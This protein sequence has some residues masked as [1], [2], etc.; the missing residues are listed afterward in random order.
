M[1]SQIPYF[2]GDSEECRTLGS[3]KALETAKANIETTFLTVGVLEDLDMT[4]QV[5]ECLMPIKFLGLAKEHAKH[6][7]HVHSHHK[8][9][10]DIRYGQF[11]KT[12][13]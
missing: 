12:M 6:D 9:K 13:Q 5:M 8:D 7:L 10:E 11:A 1:D 3:R 2:C 4:H